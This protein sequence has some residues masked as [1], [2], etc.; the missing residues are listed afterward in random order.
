VPG[1]EES[2]RYDVVVRADSRA[3]DELSPGV[4]A[5]LQTLPGVIRTVTCP[6][7][8]RRALWDEELEP[9]YAAR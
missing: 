9:G 7:V 5:P 3:L 1:A 6:S 4:I 8:A 2:S